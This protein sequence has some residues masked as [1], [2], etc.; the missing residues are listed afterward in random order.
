ME[1][2]SETVQSRKCVAAIIL[3]YSFWQR[4]VFNLLAVFISNWNVAWL[5]KRISTI[6]CVQLSIQDQVLIHPHRLPGRDRALDGVS[7]LE[8][9]H[10]PLRRGVHAAASGT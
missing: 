10:H 7:G 8:I 6:G 4:A 1:A 5:D 9:E 3:T 2:V